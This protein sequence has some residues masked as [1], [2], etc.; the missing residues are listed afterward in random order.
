MQ[1]VV[2]ATWCIIYSGY[3]PQLLLGFPLTTF[4]VDHISEVA[5][6]SCA[7]GLA[8]SAWMVLRARALGTEDP[9]MR[10]KTKDQVRSP[11]PPREDGAA[12][13]SCRFLAPVGG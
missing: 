2:I 3:I 12:F 11:P 10:S 4:M 6:A 7:L 5:G 9:A 1:L 8:L 13:G